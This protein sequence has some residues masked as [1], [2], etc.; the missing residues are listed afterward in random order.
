M[1][2][3]RPRFIRG[4]E[5]DFS[6]DENITFNGLNEF[7]VFD[8]K[9]LVYQSERITRISYDTAWH[10]YLQEDQKRTW[11]N[12]VLEK[13]INGRYLVKNEETTGDSDLE[14]DYT[15]VHFSLPG[16]FLPAGEDV[17]ISG[18]LT[19]W[20]LDDRCKMQYNFTHRRYEASI[21][22]KQGYY[23]YLYLQGNEGY[24][25]D[26][27]SIIEGN[28]WETENEYSIFVYFREPGGLTDILLTIATLTR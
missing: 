2:I 24:H 12:Y 21:L 18:A 23:N 10:I 17:H 3:T 19:G 13:E 15:W 25:S 27:E 9:S 20:G 22:L 11:K 26:T 4:N 8:T 1:Y 14:A 7:R 5:L 16:E 28:H 6:H